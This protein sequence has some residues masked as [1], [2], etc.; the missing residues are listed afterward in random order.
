MP[1]YPHQTGSQSFSQNVLDRLVNRALMELE[2]NINLSTAVIARNDVTRQS[3]KLAL[4][5][6]KLPLTHANP[7]LKHAKLN[8]AS[9]H[10]TPITTNRRKN[11]KKSLVSWCLD[12]LKTLSVATPTPD[13]ICEQTIDAPLL[14]DALPPPRKI[15]NK[16]KE[17]DHFIKFTLYGGH[18]G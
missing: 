7:P 3:R 8:L 12:G 17:L 9:T 11:T 4:N 6:D 18:H 1:F 15:G 16:L 14:Q 5:H 13:K 10:L 2:Q